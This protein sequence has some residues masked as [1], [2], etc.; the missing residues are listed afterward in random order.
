MSTNE[1]CYRRKLLEDRAAQFLMGAVGD[2]RTYN[3]GPNASQL[4]F[5]AE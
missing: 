1:E 5:G 2:A 3:L 4:A